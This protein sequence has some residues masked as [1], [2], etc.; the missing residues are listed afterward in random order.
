MRTSV[1]NLRVCELLFP[2]QQFPF[3]QGVVVAAVLAVAIYMSS[4][5]DDG[6]G[7]GDGDTSAPSAVVAEIEHRSANVMR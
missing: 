1:A 7:G 3:H 5:H 2:F 4:V 6:A